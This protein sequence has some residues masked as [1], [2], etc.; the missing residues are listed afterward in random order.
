MFLFSFSTGSAT[1]CQVG[2][3]LWLLS[4]MAVLK[5][6]LLS[7]HPGKI[8]VILPDGDP[9]SLAGA[10]TGAWRS[11]KWTSKSCGSITIA[12]APPAT[13]PT[14]TSSNHFCA[15]CVGPALAI[16]LRNT[17]VRK[18]RCA[19]VLRWKKASSPWKAVVLG[20]C[21]SDSQCAAAVCGLSEQCWA[22]IGWESFRE[23]CSTW[24]NFEW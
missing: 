9:V 22:T 12:T 13:V 14:K 16:R 2:L 24:K 23:S 3:T 21:L 18:Q 1:S 10:A 17:A 15:S 8:E 11:R 20:R 6:P 19:T 5:H 4:Y 7:A